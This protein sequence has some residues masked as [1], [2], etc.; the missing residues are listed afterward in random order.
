MVAPEQCPPPIDA[1]VVLILPMDCSVRL[2]PP[3]YYDQLVSLLVGSCC[4]LPAVLL[5]PT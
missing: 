5:L 4:D 2:F 3:S 1:M